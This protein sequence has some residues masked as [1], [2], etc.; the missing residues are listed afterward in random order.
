MGRVVG[1]RPGKVDVKFGV[2]MRTL[3]QDG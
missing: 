2:E 1:S 3:L